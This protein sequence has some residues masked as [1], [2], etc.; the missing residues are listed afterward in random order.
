M[1]KINNLFKKQKITAFLSIA[2]VLALAGL[3]V[4]IISNTTQGYVMKNAGW[5][6]AAGVAALALVSY[7]AYAH[8]SYGEKIWVTGIM[9]AALVL[10]CVSFGFTL[11]KRVDLAA[12]LFTYDSANTL[13][14]RAFNTGMVNVGLNLIA[15]IILTVCAFIN[16]GS[17]DITKNNLSV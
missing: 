3:I 6:I 17:K 15:A 14:W 16:P 5:I 2:A 4:F 11:T 13:A 9:Y 8:I 10:L 7:A 1:S 12:A